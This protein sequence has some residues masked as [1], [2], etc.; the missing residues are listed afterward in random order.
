[1]IY[2]IKLKTGFFKR[3]SMTLEISL[4][5][6][7]LHGNQG[8]RIMLLKQDILS[9]EIFD[10]TYPWELDIQTQGKNY[11]ITFNENNQKSIYKSLFR[12]YSDKVHY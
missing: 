2:P 12:Y 5:M 11:T 9:I 7:I 3:Q 4:D 8:E 6:L 10:T 1:M